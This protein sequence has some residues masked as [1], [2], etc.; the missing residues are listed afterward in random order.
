M[1]DMTLEKPRSQWTEIWQQFRAHKGAMVGMI[2]LGLLIVFVLIG[3]FIWRIDP[4]F[5]DS[6]TV[7][8]FKSR[9]LGPS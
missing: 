8:M 6:D 5:I 7:K 3:P 4:N 1:T 9:N 2:V